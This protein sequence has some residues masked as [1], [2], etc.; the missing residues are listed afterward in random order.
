MLQDLDRQKRLTEQIVTPETARSIDLKRATAIGSMLA[1]LV[2][3][4][5]NWWLQN[6]PP[7]SGP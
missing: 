2:A 7:R 5:W 1:G 3:G 6:H 4:V